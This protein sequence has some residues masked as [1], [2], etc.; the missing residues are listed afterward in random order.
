MHKI[1]LLLFILLSLNSYAQRNTFPNAH[2]VYSAEED[3]IETDEIF[4]YRD[5]DNRLIIDDIRQLQRNDFLRLE[6]ISIFSEEATYW[7]YFQLNNRTG[8]DFEFVLHGGR[9]G[10]ETYY[11]VEG[12]ET[13]VRKT[14]YHFPTNER[15]IRQ[16][17]QTR[18]NLSLPASET[19]HVYAKIESTDGNPIDIKASLVLGDIWTNRLENMNLFEGIFSGILF[20]VIILAFFI[21][22]F[23]RERV[24]LFFAFY[25]LSNL[26]YFL[27]M[28]GIIEL[29]VLTNLIDP[30]PSLWALPLLS[31]AAYFTFSRYFLETHI[32]QP[33]WDKTLI[34]LS[35]FSL[36]MFLGLST[37]LFLTGNMYLGM[38]A[39]HLTVLVLV[40][41][42]LVL[43]VHAA[44]TNNIIAKY[45][46]YGSMFFIASVLIVVL[47]QLLEPS[48]DLP[49]LVQAGIIVEIVVFS[50]GISH[51]LKRQFEDHD[52][53]QRSLI[54]Q[55]R[56]NERL[57]LDINQELEEIVAD[58]TQ[59]IKKQNQAL[60]EARQEAE[61]ATKDKS[62]FLAVMSHEIRTPLNAI[63]SLSHIMEIDNKD[64]EM[65]EYIDALKFSAEGLHS[66]INDIL[67][68]NKIEAGKLRLE[69]TEFSLIDLLR[70]LAESFKYKANNK[71]I[72]MRIEIGEHLPDRLSGDP[73][74]LTQILNNLISNA[75]K[76]TH[77]GHI[78]IKAVLAGIKDETAKVAFSVSDTG[79]GIPEDKLQA[80]FEEYEQAS[81]ETTRE[82]GGTGLGL[83]IVQKLL[84]LMGSKI[85]LKSVEDRGT[86]FSF[87][88]DFKIDP[89]FDMVDLQQQD[90]DKDLNQKK[91][92]VVD[93][94]DMN[95]LVLK[96]LFQ[97]WNA[98]FDEAD[99][100]YDALDK[101]QETE[102]DVVLM[103]IEMKPINGFDTTNQLRKMRP[104]GSPTVVAMSAH[105]AS[106]FEI[107][108]KQFGFVDFVHK[109]FDPED[110]FQKLSLYTNKNE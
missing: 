85:K 49:T 23:T 92:L 21:Y 75:I 108:L 65:K 82:Y 66:L 53:T 41:F 107:E 18:I 80:I 26:V 30:I 58:R 28:H 56:K 55:L 109:P 52:I 34:V 74:R 43:I 36:I 91:I 70:N 51:K 93:D 104:D 79:I 63:I 39:M 19:I 99:N 22:G 31:A 40:G 64:K 103:D 7:I 102:Y 106:E 16:G 100:G 14:G 54:L 12:E 83:S 48:N 50:L 10:K 77:E 15:N 72:E 47:G 73:T 78:H 81:E 96:R 86:T 88:I 42:A 27:H 87:E 68:Y 35:Y 5:D 4:V 3:I 45:F 105:N 60:K 57:Q 37:Y 89:E 101:I 25:A 2:S 44:R 6:D 29:Y 9:N 110:L 69:S 71:G 13:T 61:K 98:S 94:N 33:K 46:A 11:L 59:Q 17:Y 90:R 84:N 24:F 38:A 32:D 67:D 20:V 97:I 95:R 8:Q 76:F 62:D 1:S